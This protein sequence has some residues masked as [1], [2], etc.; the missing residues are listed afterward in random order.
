[1][2]MVDVL[3][4][5]VGLIFA[6]GALILL[7]GYLLPEKAGFILS[8]FS[9]IAIVS[10]VFMYI[11][12]EAEKTGDPNFLILVWIATIYFLIVMLLFVRIVMRRTKHFRS[13]SKKYKREA[14]QK[15]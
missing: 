8:I 3:T 11:K 14:K 15:K 9:S 6:V 2:M 7:F 5:S 1:M 13:E 4:V 12:P 10:I